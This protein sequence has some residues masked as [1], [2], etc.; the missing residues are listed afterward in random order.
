MAL[1]DWLSC[2]GAQA[3]VWV[4]CGCGVRVRWAGG[5]GLAVGVGWDHM[6]F[7]PVLSLPGYTCGSPGTWPVDP[8]F[9]RWC[10]WTGAGKA[11]LQSK[12]RLC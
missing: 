6:G 3:L 1:S 4:G 5:V 8:L 11:A 7:I 12:P 9:L 10:R 2:G